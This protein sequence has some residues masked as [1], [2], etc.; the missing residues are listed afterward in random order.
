MGLVPKHSPKIEAGTD[1]PDLIT[2][3]VGNERGLRV[4]EDD[5]LLTIDPARLAD[6][7]SDD[8]IEAEHGDSV[9]KDHFRSIEVLALPREDVNE[10]C[11]LGREGRARR[12]DCRPFCLAVRN[13]TGFRAREEVVELGV[14]HCEQLCGIVGHCDSLLLGYENSE[15]EGRLDNW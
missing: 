3:P 13:G 2:Y 11:N 10:L 4:V 9:H 8:G 6:D 12:D 15:Q 14:G 1:E 5:A 7:A